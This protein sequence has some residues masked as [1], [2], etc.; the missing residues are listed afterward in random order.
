MLE[1]ALLR[2]KKLMTKT[3]DNKVDA[4]YKALEGRLIY[5]FPYKHRQILRLIYS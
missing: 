2:G 3:K 1:K 5:A 4:I